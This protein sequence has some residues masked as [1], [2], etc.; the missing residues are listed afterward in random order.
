M[1]TRVVIAGGGVAALEAALA[2]RALAEERVEIELVGPEPH[3]WY[4]PLSVAEPFELG[5]THRYEL[6]ALAAAAGATFTL[7][8]LQ[9]VDA[10]RPRGEDLGRRDPLRRPARRG[11][12]RPDRRRP[13]RPDVPRPGRY[14]QDPHPARGDRRGRRPPG[15]LRRAVGRGLVAADLRARADDRGI[16]R[17]AADPRGRADARHA[18]RGA[19]P[20]LRTCRQRRRP[21]APRRARDRARDGSASGRVRRTAGC[22]SCPTAEL[23]VDRVVALPRLRGARFDGLPQTLDG[24]IPI[25]AHGRVRGL[26]DVYAAGDITNF[27]VKQGGIAT[28]LADAAAEAIARAA[29]ADLRPEPF[30]PVLR[31]LLLTGGAAALSPPRADRRRPGRDRQP[32][33]ALVAAGEDRRPPP[34][35]LPRRLRRRREPAGALGRPG[36]FGSRSSSQPGSRAACRA[37][38]RGGA[39]RGRDRRERPCPPIRSSSRP[40]TSSARWPRR[41]ATA[42]PARRPSPSRGELVGILTSRDLLRAF[43]ARVEPAERASVSG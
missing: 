24:F 2:L 1:A 3:F 21:R 40:R 17:R 26:D 16:S 41:C 8:T 35:A 19:A 29:G 4:R 13:G 32:R 34:R 39:G 12:R 9:G 33:S 36:A 11:R 31:G 30:R 38:A 43:A 27:P 18:R 22:G 15:R 23:E 37:A 25:D 6:G 20:A 5:E 42:T 10:A 7:G 28:Q 14:G